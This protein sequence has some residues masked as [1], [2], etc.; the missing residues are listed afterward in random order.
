MRAHGFEIDVVRDAEFEA[1]VKDFAK[2]R[3]ESD[4]VSGLIA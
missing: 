2:N 4:A 3:Q 1:A